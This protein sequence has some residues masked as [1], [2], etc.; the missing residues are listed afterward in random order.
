VSDVDI[1]VAV[2]DEERVLRGGGVNPRRRS[3]HMR[4]RP[5]RRSAVSVAACV[6]LGAAGGIAGSAASTRHSSTTARQ[7]TGF[8]WRFDRHGPGGRPVHAE[9]V[10]LDRAGT[11]FITQTEDN[12][13]V[14]S[15]SGS[16][17]TIT[18]AAN[19]V[20]YKDVTVTIP[21]GATIVRNGAT[22]SLSDL[23]AGDHVDVRS[24]SD[25]TSVFAFDSSF[26]PPQ[27]PRG[28]WRPGAPP[29][30]GMP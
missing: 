19:G 7:S 17:L 12:G 23:K 26:V 14:K 13:T 29:P 8:G 9:E 11:A 10:V 21:S 5:N 24:S 15:V 25:G 4:F 18:E 20:T 2:L 3:H 16:D 27:G 30:P 22:A 6:A 1:V 28:G